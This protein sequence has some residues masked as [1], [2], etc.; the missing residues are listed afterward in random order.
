MLYEKFKIPNDSVTQN[1]N[2]QLQQTYFAFRKEYTP[3]SLDLVAQ[4]EDQTLLAK[5]E[6]QIFYGNNLLVN[7][8]T[9]RVYREKFAIRPPTDLNSQV[10]PSKTAV[11]LEPNPESKLELSVN[12]KEFYKAHL[13]EIQ[14]ELKMHKSRLMTFFAKRGAKRLLETKKYKILGEL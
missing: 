8:T 4:I 6:N 7:T 10:T 2:E 13:S 1:Y 3:Y 9:S 11:Q 12:F 14:Y 5:Q